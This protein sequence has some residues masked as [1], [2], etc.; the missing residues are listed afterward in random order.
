VYS[1]D[2][3]AARPFTSFDELAHYHTHKFDSHRY[4]RD[5]SSAVLAAERALEERQPGYRALLFGSGMAACSALLGVLDGP[6]WLPRECYRKMDGATAKRQRHIYD[7]VWEV[8]PGGIVWAESPSNPHLRVA[9]YAALLSLPNSR[10]VLD[11]TFAGL[12]NWLGGDW[13]VAIVHSATKYVCGHNDVVAGLVYVKPELYE[14]LWA[15]RSAYGGILDP[16]S[17]WLLSRSLQTY[18]IRI[19][20][21]LENTWS[22]RSALCGR[23]IFYPD[24]A[25]RGA[26]HKHGGAVVS[27]LANGEPEELTDKCG[28][29][30]TIKMAASFGAVTSL[31]EVPSTMSRFGL[32]REELV[33]A[34]IEPNLI[35]LSVGI[36]PVDSILSDLEV[37][38]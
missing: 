21:Q 8:D 11:L 10:V 25:E 12:S 1:I 28:R 23:E 30:Q 14:A 3:C 32:S 34:G 33:I 35:R 18:D 31:I 6:L 36:E 20:R 7:G 29:M 19:E 22:V 5:S 17:A 24:A 13:P 38:F 27:F 37:L 9:D 16:W 2:T 15:H 4:G 26:W